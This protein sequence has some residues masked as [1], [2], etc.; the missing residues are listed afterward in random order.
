MAGLWLSSRSSL[1]KIE[2]PNNRLNI[3]IIGT[4]NRAQANITGVASENIVASCDIDDDYLAAMTQK[5]PAA[6]RYND[7]RKLLEQK[8]IDAVVISTADHTHAVIAV[9]AMK[10]GKHVY[11]EKP[12][13]HTVSEARW[14]ARAAAE[15]KLATQMG[16][17]IHAEKNYRRVVE[18]IQHGDIG[19][20]T[21][22]HVWCEKSWSGGYRPAE[23]PPI[24]SRLH[25]DL[26]LGPAPERPYHPDYLPKNWRRWW[27]FGN[28]TLGDMGCHYLDLV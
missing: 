15:Y 20:V 28:G 16:T 19:P 10:A 4:A 8:N 14:V 21:E 7:F 6:K 24:P 17:Q 12:L 25:W 11:C 13:A 27:D 26:W 9:A 22:C 3:G 2:S 23:K 1:G 18:L 5:F